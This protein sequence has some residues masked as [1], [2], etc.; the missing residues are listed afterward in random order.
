MPRSK[1][2]LPE[3]FENWMPFF[4]RHDGK[5]VIDGKQCQIQT[6]PNLFLATEIGY[7][8]ESAKSV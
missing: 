8:A 3:R 4:H 2:V 7:N 6:A 5:P 1:T